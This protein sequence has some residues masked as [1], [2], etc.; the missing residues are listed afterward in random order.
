ML[1][2]NITLWID[3]YLQWNSNGD[4]KDVLKTLLFHSHLGESIFKKSMG[5]NVHY[6]NTIHGL[7][8]YFWPK[9]NFWILFSVNFKS[10]CALLSFNCILKCGCFNLVWQILPVTGLITKTQHLPPN[11]TRELSWA[12]GSCNV[13]QRH[14]SR[15]NKTTKGKPP[16]FGLLWVKG[17]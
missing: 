4:L 2:F 16:N 11:R 12:T 9:L 3:W 8:Q 14:C 7:V 5:Q 10:T 15:V 17:L 13:S 1:L 6:E